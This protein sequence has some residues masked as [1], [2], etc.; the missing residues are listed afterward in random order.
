MTD[1]RVSNASPLIVLA[2]ID[3][4]DIF[5]AL[6]A[7]VRVPATVLTEVGA[8]AAADRADDRVR[9]SGRFTL[10]DDVPISAEVLRWASIEGKLRRS[11]RRSQRM[12]RARSSTTLAARRCAQAI[13]LRLIGT[14]GLIARAKRV[15]IVAE[16]APVIAAVREVGLYLSDELTRAVLKELGEA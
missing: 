9:Q 3:R 11:R 10:V 12:R 14:L 16:A 1:F 7:E 2:A 8:G 13:G 6:N 4:L 15:G 5:A